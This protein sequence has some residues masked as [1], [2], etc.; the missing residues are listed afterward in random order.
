MKHL[1]TLR[2]NYENYS[3]TK[4][5]IAH[6]MKDV[7][8]FTALAVAAFL[9]FHNSTPTPVALVPGTV[10]PPNVAS[11]TIPAPSA[12][13]RWKTGPNAQTEFEPFAPNEHATWNT[14][15]LPGYTFN[16]RTG[17]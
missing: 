16:R 8:L 10:S 13:S 9:Y 14:H 17:R 2:L 5:Y 1:L 11:V 12:Y 6:L 3:N 7:I 4:T 15:S